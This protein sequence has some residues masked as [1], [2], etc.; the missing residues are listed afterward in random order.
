MNNR[1]QI[2]YN[3]FVKEVAQILINKGYIIVDYLANA[4]DGLDADAQDIQSIINIYSNEEFDDIEIFENPYHINKIV[5]NKNIMEYD[6]N[7]ISEIIMDIIWDML[8]DNEI[9]HE[10]FDD[11][12][13][14]NSINNKYAYGG[15][16]YEF[17]LQL[18]NDIVKEAMRICQDN[19]VEESIYTK[20]DKHLL[21]SLIEKY[22]TKG[23]ERAIN[24]L[25]E[26][27]LDDFDIDGRIERKR[28]AVPDNIK[29]KVK[30]LLNKTYQ[31]I[32]KYCD[33]FFE[34][35]NLNI[36]NSKKEYNTNNNTYVV[37]YPDLLWGFTYNEND[38]VEFI[39][40]VGLYGSI[41]GNRNYN[42]NKQLLIELG[43]FLKSH[44]KGLNYRYGDIRK[45][46]MG[47]IYSA[48]YVLPVSIKLKDL[49]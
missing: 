49:R 19:K 31:K 16:G 10:M 17:K 7:Y 46:E 30:N 35:N 13:D 26:D 9:Y 5:S 15:G 29:L 34:M 3:E 44:V 27:S 18:I 47:E 23:V 33:E 32:Y 6:N 39:I 40:S 45:T 43:D 25:N 41:V 37:Y 36:Q 8:D 24:R 38:S 20:K 1:Y 42:E 4:I 22:G 48:S 11:L 12:Y 2:T 14:I 21:E 28:N